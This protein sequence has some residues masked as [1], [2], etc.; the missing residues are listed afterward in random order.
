MKFTINLI[1]N[2]FKLSF[3]VTILSIL[4]ALINNFLGWICLKFLPI[5][6][7]SNKL[8]SIHT[9]GSITMTII[10]LITI[11]VYYTRAN[12]DE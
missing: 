7:G 12:S 6:S 8:E 2:L 1:K 9:Y 4:L 3:L 10:L 11:A 5:L